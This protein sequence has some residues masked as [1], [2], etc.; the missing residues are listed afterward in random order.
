MRP[1]SAKTNDNQRFKFGAA[2]TQ[3]NSLQMTQ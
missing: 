2:Q 1:Q 3:Q